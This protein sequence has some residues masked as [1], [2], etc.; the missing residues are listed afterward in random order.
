MNSSARRAN[1]L[2]LYAV[3]VL[4]AGCGGGSQLGPNQKIEAR[5]WMAPEARKTDLAYVSGFNNSG[6]DAFTYPGG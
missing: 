6:I 1:A 3:V 2:V 4:A 5:S